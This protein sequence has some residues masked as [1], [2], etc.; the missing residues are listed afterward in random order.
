VWDPLRSVSPIVQDRNY[1]CT[2][3]CTCSIIMPPPRKK[4]TTGVEGAESLVRSRV[5]QDRHGCHVTHVQCA[6][7]SPFSG[8]PCRGPRF[9]PSLGDG[10]CTYSTVYIHIYQKNDEKGTSPPTSEPVPRVSAVSR[11]ERWPCSHAGERLGM[12]ISVVWWERKG[13]GEG[14]RERGTRKKKVP[15]GR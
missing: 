14:E 12:V 5:I 1:H 9:W 15:G 6:L 11:G 8:S 4:S 10:I 13:T 3:Q 2:R 7:D